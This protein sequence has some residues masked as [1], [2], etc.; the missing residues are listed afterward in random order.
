MMNEH[1][2]MIYVAK[3]ISERKHGTQELWQS[4]LDSARDCV[5][6]I[7]QLGFLNKRKFWG[8]DNNQRTTLE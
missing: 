4:E 2:N 5:L 7:E 3:I 1:H 6:L 8:N